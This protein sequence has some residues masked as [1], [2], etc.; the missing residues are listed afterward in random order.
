MF[1]TPL[2]AC[3]SGAATVS[4]SVSALAPG[5]AAVTTTVGGAMLGYCAIGS[6]G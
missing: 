5:K 2:I 4:A 6:D 1:S 3:S